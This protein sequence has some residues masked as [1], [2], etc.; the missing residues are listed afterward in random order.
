VTALEQRPRRCESEALR[1]PCDQNSRHID[2]GL[3]LSQES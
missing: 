3:R 2:G 1:G